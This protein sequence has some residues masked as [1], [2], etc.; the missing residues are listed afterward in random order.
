MGIIQIM[1]KIIEIRNLEV[2]NNIIDIRICIKFDP[3]NT[4]LLFCISK[5]VLYLCAVLRPFNVF[6]T[7]EFRL[8]EIIGDLK[9]L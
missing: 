3:I 5:V 4:T 9:E 7:F 1:G 2:I 8:L 6:A